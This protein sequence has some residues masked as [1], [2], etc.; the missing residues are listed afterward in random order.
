MIHTHVG[1]AVAAQFPADQRAA[2]GAAIDKGMQGTRLIARHHHRSVPD[3]GRL[4]IP[5]GRQLGFQGD[6]VPGW[7]AE[8]LFLFQFVDQGI[9]KNPIGNPAGTLCGPGEIKGT[10]RRQRMHA[11]TSSARPFSSD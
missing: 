5:W 9:K 11:V 1:S 10:L 3:K 2:M 4:K 6:I 7:S 8:Q